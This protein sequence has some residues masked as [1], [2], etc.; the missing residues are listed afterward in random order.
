LGKGSEYLKE[1]PKPAS[2]LGTRAKFH[3]KRTAKI[4]IAADKLKKIHLQAL[5]L[6]AVNLEQWEWSLKE[7]QRKNKKKRGTGWVQTYATGASNISVEVTLKRD[8]EKAIMQCIKQFGL[9]PKSE[10]ELTREIDP[11]QGDL[12]EGFKQLKTGE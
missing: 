11:A 1:M 2:Y 9:D 4:L 7:I 6:M 3:F 10:K 5:E 12:F 8:A